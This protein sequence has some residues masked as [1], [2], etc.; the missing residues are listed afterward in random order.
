[1]VGYEVEEQTHP[2]LMDATAE[3]LQSGIP[4]KIGM[5]RVRLDC[6][7]RAAN[8]VVRE[9]GQQTLIFASPVGILQRDLASGFSRLPNTEKPNPVEAALRD[10]VQVRV[11]DIIE[12]G[13]PPQ[14][15]G[16][17]GQ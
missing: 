2:S 7:T 9:V 5:N 10:S 6:K 11:W 12:C 15:P 1:M 8:I 16:E 14:F 13:R 17:S 4:A 3:T